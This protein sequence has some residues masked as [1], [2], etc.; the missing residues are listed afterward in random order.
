MGATNLT[1]DEFFDAYRRGERAEQSPDEAR[2]VNPY[3]PDTPKGREL[4]QA[5]K[6]GFLHSR[7]M[8]SAIDR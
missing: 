2:R 4:Y 3:V 1:R 5:W 7:E 6:D 8:H